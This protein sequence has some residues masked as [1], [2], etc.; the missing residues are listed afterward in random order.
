VTKPK[1]E[2]EAFI[3]E[4][5]GIEVCGESEAGPIYSLAD[6]ATVAVPMDGDDFFYALGGPS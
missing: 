3:E 5:G 1:R 4:H 2:L 6:G